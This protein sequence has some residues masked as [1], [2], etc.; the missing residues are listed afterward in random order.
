MNCAARKEKVRLLRL[1]SGRQGFTLWV[2]FRK[3]SSREMHPGR[4]LRKWLQR[5]W[6]F[7]SSIYRHT[8]KD[9][10]RGT[11]MDHSQ[12]GQFLEEQTPATG[13]DTALWTELATSL[14]CKLCIG[15]GVVE[16]L[17]SSH[18]C[19]AVKSRFVVNVFEHSVGVP[20]ASL[21]V[22]ECYENHSLWRKGR[23]RGRVN[24]ILLRYSRQ[25]DGR[26]WNACVVS[27]MF[28][29][30]AGVLYQSVPLP[31]DSAFCNY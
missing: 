8:E 13:R 10:S 20:G 24:L 22:I 12:M 16:A 14:I 23:C 29:R 15:I 18:M 7:E 9:L 27:S 3:E 25:W 21:E 5:L 17:T 4:N 28:W 31:Y 2:K 11:N 26:A 30:T 6:G 19:L 1:R